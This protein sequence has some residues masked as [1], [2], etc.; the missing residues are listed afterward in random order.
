MKFKEYKVAGLDRPVLVHHQED[1]AGEAIIEWWDETYHQVRLPAK[2]LLMLSFTETKRWVL[3]QLEH[4]LD[5]EIATAP[6][7]H[8][9]RTKP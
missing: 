6:S 1:W 5:K 7:P 4:A 8:R 9:E 2:I 3:E